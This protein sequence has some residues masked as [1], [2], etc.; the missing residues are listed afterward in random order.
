MRILGIDPGLAATGYG[1]VDSTIRPLA[2]E[3]WGVITTPKTQLHRERLKDIQDCVVQLVT[4]WEVKVAVVER[5]IF[6]EAR[7]HA[8]QTSEARGAVLAGLARCGIEV[9]EFTPQQAKLEVAGHGRAEKVEVQ[10]A[11]QTILGMATLPRPNHAA[12]ALAQIITYL[13]RRTA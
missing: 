7:H 9:V 6:T 2:A 8:Q 3:T 13:N 5:M 4:E 1:V 11:V 12:D 10:E